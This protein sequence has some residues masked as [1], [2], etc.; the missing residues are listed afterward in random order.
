MVSERR[1]GLEIECGLNGDIGTAYERL[2]REVGGKWEEVDYDGTEYEIRTPVFQGERGFAQLETT[3]RILREEGGYV[4][5]EDGGHVHLE[6]LDFEGDAAKVATLIRSWV[7]LEP[8]IESLVSPYRRNN[9]GSCPKIW[10]KTHAKA[11]WLR[12]RNAYTSRG[13]LN[14][15]NIMGS[16]RGDRKSNFDEDG[17]CYN[18][19][20]PREYCYCGGRAPTIELRLHEGTLNYDHM[21]AWIQMG[22]ALLDKVSREGL[23]IRSCARPDAL[24]RRLDLD[25]GVGAVLIEKAR[26]VQ[27]PDDMNDRWDD[28]WRY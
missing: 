6:A 12:G 14:V 15:N 28:G 25:N 17:Y 18:C 11:S 13:N 8:A 23:T 7:N 5:S 24:V 19:E 4:T 9:Y 10:R 16:I 21:R 2:E 27:D 20:E 3:Y 22:Q 26:T 1:F